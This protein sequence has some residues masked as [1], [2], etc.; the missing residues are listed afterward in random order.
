M[1]I[2]LTFSKTTG[3]K[4]ARG[5]FASIRLQ[6]GQISDAASG[7]II[8]THLPHG[9]QVDGEDYLRLDATGPVSVTWEG[10]GEALATTGHFSSINGVAYIDRRI[11]AFMD[12]EC[13]DWYL[14][15]EGKHQPVLTL[16]GA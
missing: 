11:L 12:R 15:R 5:P 10:H 8:A 9:W 6:G 4:A 14:V 7:R 16:N 1:T 3:E 2:V 13:N